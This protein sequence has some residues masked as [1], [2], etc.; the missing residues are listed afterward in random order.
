M[1]QRNSKRTRRE[2]QTPPAR[3]GHPPRTFGGFLVQAEARF[4]AGSRFLGMP[5]QY[6]RSRRGGRAAKRKSTILVTISCL[7]VGKGEIVT[8]T[9]RGAPFYAI[10]ACM[11]YVTAIP[12]S[13]K[14]RKGKKGLPSAILILV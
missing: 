3:V 13:L 4:F 2:R 5:P 1:I 9:Y 12:L 14:S 10:N 6:P 7:K 11:F 8:S